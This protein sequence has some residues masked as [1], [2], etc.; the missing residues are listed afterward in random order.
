MLD[1]LRSQAMPRN[2]SHLEKDSLEPEKARWVLSLVNTS[3]SNFR[4]SDTSH[5]GIENFRD[6]P[7]GQN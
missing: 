4:W 3:R 7:C 5:M 1:V 2:I 6:M